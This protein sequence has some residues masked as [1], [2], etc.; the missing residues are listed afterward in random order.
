[1]FI[2]K[3]KRKLLYHLKG[4][5]QTTA[6][7]VCVNNNQKVD[8]QCQHDKQKMGIFEQAAGTCNMVMNFW[9]P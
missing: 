6:Y 2:L 7:N 9:A 8:P 1:M 3:Y 4:K 5:V